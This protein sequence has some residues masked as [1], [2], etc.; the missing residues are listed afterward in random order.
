MHQE[1]ES[2]VFIV[3]VS[4]ACG[5]IILYTD[6]E[7]LGLLY[8]HEH[9]CSYIHLLAV[10][11]CVVEVDIISSCSLLSVS[12]VFSRTTELIFQLVV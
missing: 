8:S 10:G 4:Q 12:G 6:E 2:T 11:K 9:V 1:Y 3:T 5:S 7:K